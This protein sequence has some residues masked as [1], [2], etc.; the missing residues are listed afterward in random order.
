[1]YLNQ[2]NEIDPLLMVESH[3]LPRLDVA[4]QLLLVLDGGEAEFLNGRVAFGKTSI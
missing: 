4:H 1:M 2:V 3:L